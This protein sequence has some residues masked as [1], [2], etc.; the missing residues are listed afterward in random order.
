MIPTLSSE[1]RYTNL[2]FFLVF[3]N[4]TWAKLFKGSESSNEVRKHQRIP[5]TGFLARP[6]S[7]ELILDARWFFGF[8]IHGFRGSD[9]NP[10]MCCLA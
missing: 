9:A 1:A 2:D 8:C 10:H 6:G 7:L 3:S 5:R 4:Y